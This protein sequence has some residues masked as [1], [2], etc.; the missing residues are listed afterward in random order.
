MAIVPILVYIIVIAYLFSKSY[1][2]F[3]TL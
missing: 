3:S 2:S 1:V